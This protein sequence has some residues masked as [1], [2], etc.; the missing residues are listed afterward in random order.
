M[1]RKSSRNW[2]TFRASFW[3]VCLSVVTVTVCVGHPPI[4]EV[5]HPELCIESSNP[6]VQRADSSSFFAECGAFPLSRKSYSLVLS[7]WAPGSH[8]FPV[9]ASLSEQLPLTQSSLSANTPPNNH[10]V[11]LL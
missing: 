9:P 4:E 3:V 10:S 5:T 1:V 8:L 2:P 7:S 6:V 11:L